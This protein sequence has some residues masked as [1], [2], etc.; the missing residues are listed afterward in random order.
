M[1][2]GCHLRIIGLKVEFGW[3][4]YPG[5]YRC[6]LQHLLLILPAL[7]PNKCCNVSRRKAVCDLSVQ[8]MLSW[9]RHQHHSASER[10]SII[11]TLPVSLQCLAKQVFQPPAVAAAAC[12]WLNIIHYSALQLQLHLHNKPSIQTTGG[13]TAKL[14]QLPH[15][16]A[17]LAEE[18]LHGSQDLHMLALELSLFERFP[19]RCG[20]QVWVPSIALAS[21]QGHL[22]CHP[23]S[24]VNVTQVFSKCS[25]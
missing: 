16:V 13:S 9:N 3:V 22:S 24:P 18:R 6:D 21:W 14:V 23:H 5:H 1:E 15:L 10:A 17:M 12:V 2:D 4:R 19:Q 11:Q 25:A 20:L 7:I 8:G